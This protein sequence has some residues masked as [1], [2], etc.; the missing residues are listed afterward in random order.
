MNVTMF[1][2]YWELFGTVASM[3]FFAGT[4]LAGQFYMSAKLDYKIDELKYSMNERFDKVDERLFR[5][6]DR[7]NS[8]D[9]RMSILEKKQ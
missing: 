9:V 1:V 3:A 5:I 7:L 6:E 2:R 4:L 8:F